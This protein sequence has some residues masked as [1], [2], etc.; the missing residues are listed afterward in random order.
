MESSSL[1][2]AL[3]VYIS[4][5]AYVFEPNA[6]S[7]GGLYP[8][9][10]DHRETMSINRR[11]GEITL[12]APN[13]GAPIGRE[14]VITCFG[15]VGIVTLAT[16]DFI[17]VITSRTP[18]CR[19]LSHPIYLAN[20]FRL[21]PLSNL[22]SSQAILD[23]PVERELVSLVE[24]GLRAGRLWFSYG[25]DLTNSLQ[26]QQDII[27][28]G[29]SGEPMWK[30]ADDRFFWNK[31]LM[32]K[33]IETTELGGKQNDLSRFIL[34]MMF[35]SVELRSST[36][37]NHDILFSLIARR[38]RYRAGTRYFTRGIDTTGHVANY[39]ETEQMVLTDPINVDPRTGFAMGG[40][41]RVE[42]KE[43]NSFVQIRGSI[44]LFWAEVNNLRY[45][46]DMQIEALKLHVE[47]QVRIY[48]DTYFV[49]LVN[50]KGHELPVKDAMEKA[51][52]ACGE[53]KAHYVYFD[54][55][56]ECR[57]LRFHR[58]QLLVDELHQDLAQMGY[59][60]INLG[61]DAL[62]AKPTHRQTGVIRSN[63]MDCLDRTNVTQA[64]LAKDA[65][66]RQLQSI[67]VLAH[68][69]TIDDH[70]EFIH[71][72]R[73][74]WADHAD[75][76][77]K[78]YSGTG[79]LKT[80]FTRTGQR[81]KQGAAQDGVNSVMRYVKNN[82]FDGSRQDA[83]DVLTGA[84]VARRGAIPPLSDTRPFLTR[85]MP[86]VLGFAMFMIACGIVLPKATEFALTSYIFF[87]V[88]LAGAAASY[89]WAH[90]TSY[91][92]WPRLNA[93]YEILSY[94]G[95]GFRTPSRGRGIAMAWN[96]KVRQEAG[97]SG[98]RKPRP[99]EIELGR[100]KG[101]LID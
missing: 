33:L 30:K 74:V 73:N 11:T 20:D 36:I 76:I 42:G 87:W 71:V 56:H 25:W 79:A 101:S 18:S 84:W 65:L 44:P 26:R 78:A 14:K 4:D 24:Q 53:P 91:V 70:S 61:G 13:I 51:L 60:H 46:P 38:S 50:N 16:T 5:D 75:T 10:K 88:L 17:I 100:K 92:N 21:L 29:R 68:K 12:N 63:C 35:G 2:E 94:K 83:Y 55:H 7:A 62:T 32:A 9:E 31:H 6:L 27:E 43:R 77:S 99:E 97:A 15:I 81:T 59:F 3:N 64:A 85:M 45:K 28:A 34:P 93:P 1:H 37:N 90:G 19:L 95:P 82:F 66:Q 40:N 89:I 52:K 39:N 22:S 49:N 41:G 58:I 96:R 86:Y 67:G 69:E 98:T 8:G 48:G 23:N 72:F 57:G 47:E 80:D 54:F